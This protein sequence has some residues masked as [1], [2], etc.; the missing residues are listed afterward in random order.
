MLTNPLLQNIS[1]ISKIDEADV[2]DDIYN[3]VASTDAM[4]KPDSVD[5][6]KLYLYDSYK[7]LIKEYKDQLEKV[8]SEK[9]KTEI[10]KRIDGILKV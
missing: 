8:E 6:A 5:S 1:V 4:T 2:K 7:A 9:D 3:H 10:K